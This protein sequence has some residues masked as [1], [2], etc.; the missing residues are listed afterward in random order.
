MQIFVG[1]LDPNITEEE[2][3]QTF[4]QFGEIAYVKIPSGKGCGFV[5]FGTRCVLHD[6]FYWCK[7]SKLH[8]CLPWKK[9]VN[10]NNGHEVVEKK[11]LVE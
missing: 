4:L 3:K 7:L 1:N 8:L 6:S 11:N 10:R 9:A 5:Q 2:L